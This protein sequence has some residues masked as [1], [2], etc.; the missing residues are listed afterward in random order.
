MSQD[1]DKASEFVKACGECSD[2]TANTIALAALHQASL[3]ADDALH[4]SIPLPPHIA[5]AMNSLAGQ[6]RN[7]DRDAIRDMVGVL[8][9]VPMKTPVT[10]IVRQDGDHGI[11]SIDMA[12]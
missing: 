3:G 2:I 4:R 8:T 6:R 12:P 7:I 10:V 9:P 1:I 11:V 5:S